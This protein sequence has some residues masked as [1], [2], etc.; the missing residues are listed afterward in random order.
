MT[1]MF[2]FALLL[3]ASPCNGFSSSSVNL[4][5][6]PQNIFVPR[7]SRQWDST[8]KHQ[9]SYLYPTNITD[10]A[11]QV[12]ESPTSWSFT[13]PTISIRPKMEFPSIEFPSAMIQ[14][15]HEEYVSR[16][17]IVKKRRVFRRLV[18]I[19]TILC[20]QIL[21]PLLCSIVKTKPDLS[22]I[23]IPMDQDWDAFWKQ[24][25]GRRKLTNAERVAQGV[26]ALGPTFV[27]LA[28]ILATRPDILP[29][30]LA[31]ALGGLQDQ[32]IPFDNL[33]AKRMIRTDMKTALLERET[34]AQPYLQSKQDIDVF[35]NSLSDKPVAAACV[36]Q[37]YKGLLP[38]YGPVAV[39]VLRPGIQR[40]VERDATL[41]HSVATWVE[42]LNNNTMKLPGMNKVNIGSIQLVH[43]VDEFTS[44]VLEDMDFT[45][46]A[47]NMKA[48]AKLYDSRTGTS[49]TVKVVV[50]EVIQELSSNRVIVMEWL[51]GTQLTDICND[52]EDQE[53]QR[54]ENL[55]LIVQAIEMT[56]S[57]FIDHGL[58]HGDPHLGNVKKVRNPKTG[59]PELG[60]LDFG[61]VSY[62]PQ[63]FRDGIV[64]AVVQL[65]F[66]RNL[67]AI[68]DLCV[69]LGLLP[70]ETLRD[71]GERQRFLKALKS[72]LSDVLIWPKDT[73]G[74][75]TAVP[76]I[77]FDSLLPVFSGLIRSF[78]FTVP[79][80]FLNNIRALATLEGMA[81]K[82][83][84]DFKILRVI[85]PYSINRLM[86]NP[87][88]SKRV[89]Q[90]FLDICRSPDTQLISPRRVQMLLNDWALWTGY[91]K[92]RI[93]WDLVTCAGGRR[94]TPVIL[95]N[96]LL[97]RIRN[98]RNLASHSGRVVVLGCRKVAT[99]IP[100]FGQWEE[101][102]TYY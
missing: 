9:F 55:E 73:K 59:L 24:R 6:Q 21:R 91:R 78:E 22:T 81:L 67:E 63:R 4:F 94:V 49:P 17:Q 1:R 12:P 57:Q 97:N 16:H 79:P 33:T 10:D 101:L 27:K 14:D 2:T 30:P 46:E 68:A 93:A 83:D 66:A 64:I 98:I 99:A 5:F 43:T 42:R 41:F 37:V 58:L 47:E 7:H 38:G 69:D 60:Y 61:L 85:Y 20:G 53:Q 77:R 74:M 32:M 11:L 8:P 56:V 87:A 80:Y 40:K 89:Q 15:A 23:H 51:E 75:S 102:A 52:C 71:A 34:Q 29:V 35:M 82:L 18:E 86:R 50:P 3:L 36:A 44:R 72:A 62:V 48:F 88:V 65:V 96:W 26:P 25:R 54:K 90:T 31:E 84:P 76:I 39:K 28:Q 100:L 45:R 13:F 95:H 92:R 70:E 19:T